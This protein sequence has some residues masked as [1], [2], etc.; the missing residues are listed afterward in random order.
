[1][2]SKI[3]LVLSYVAKAASVLTGLAAYNDLVPAKYAALA[4]IVFAASSLTKDT[5]N[6]IADLADDGQENQSWK[7]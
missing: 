1:M 7:G 6:R 5:V 3:L 2:K 4:A